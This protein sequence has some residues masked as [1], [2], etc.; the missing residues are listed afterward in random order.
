VQVGV[1]WLHPRRFV[2]RWHGRPRS[3]A[4][5]ATMIADVDELAGLA[6]GATAQR[7]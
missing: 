3:A 7:N 2:R 1:C 5:T 6:G 4:D